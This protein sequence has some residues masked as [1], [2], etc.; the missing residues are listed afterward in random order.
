MNPESFSTPPTQTETGVEKRREV[1]ETIKK[2]WAVQFEAAHELIERQDGVT[3]R[4]GIVRPE[5]GKE[6]ADHWYQATKLFQEGLEQERLAAEERG[7]REAARQLALAETFSKSH[8][9]SVASYLDARNAYPEL[10]ELME[11]IYPSYPQK[12]EEAQQAYGQ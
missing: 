3:I 12:L 1:A 9:D 11:E 2:L 10:V 4:E 7:D 8:H 6:G 5:K